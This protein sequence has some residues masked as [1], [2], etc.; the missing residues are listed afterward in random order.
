MFT[1]SLIILVMVGM[2]FAFTS[3]LLPGGR[4]TRSRGSSL[5]MIFGGGGGGKVLGDPS[6]Y[7]RPKKTLILWE[8]ESSAPSK[9][10]RQACE[11]LDLTVEHRPCPGGRYGFSDQLQT[12]SQGGR[13]TP[14]LRD[15][16]NVIGGLNQ[17]KNP[18]E[19]VAYLF[20]YYGP[21]IDKIPGSLKGKG[22]T[23]P[24]GVQPTKN[25]NEDNILQKPLVLY[26]FESNGDSKGVRETMSGLCLSFTNINCCTGS[27]GAEALKKKGGKVPMIEDPNK[28]VTVQGKKEIIKHLLDNY[29]T[30]IKLKSRK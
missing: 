4:L 12:A 7:P 6:T 22:L 1:R 8:Y 24:S 29:C 20:E 23:N 26:G 30:G 17:M 21:G 9:Q 19:I 15:P 2:A 13:T 18:A 25:W 14:F 16:G 3:G 10:V 27:K 28:R 11:L 5:N